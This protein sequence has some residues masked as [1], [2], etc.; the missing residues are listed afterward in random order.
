MFLET[1]TLL[2]Q[3]MADGVEA[4]VVETGDLYGTSLWRRKRRTNEHE[5]SDLSGLSDLGGFL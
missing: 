3:S 1:G 2:Q 5:G 4:E